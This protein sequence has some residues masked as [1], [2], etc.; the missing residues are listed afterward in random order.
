MQQR[1]TDHQM[2]ANSFNVLDNDEDDG[3]WATSDEGEDTKLNSGVFDEGEAT[4]FTPA[5]EKTL[6]GSLALRRLTKSTYLPKKGN[7]CGKGT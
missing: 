6:C 2:T 1:I 4:D 5:Y 3:L 7:T